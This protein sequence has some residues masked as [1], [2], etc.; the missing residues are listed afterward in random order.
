MTEASTTSRNLK[1]GLLWHTIGHGNLGIDALARGHIA[2]ISEAARQA[3]VSFEAV[4]MGSGTVAT[5]PAV[6]SGVRI[7]PP[8]RPKALLQGDFSFLETIRGCDVVFDIGE[9]DG[10][11]D[12]YGLRRYVL[13]MGSKLA[14]MGQGKPLYLAPQTI[15][16]FEKPLRRK[17][18][19]AL[20]RRASGVFTRD[21]LSTQFLRENALPADDHEF[22]DVAFALPFER[23]SHSPDRQ[24][25]CIN[26]SG[27]LYNKGY[28]GK[29]E[30]GMTLDYPAFTHQLI[31][32]LL[33]R[34][35]TE[36]HLI[37]HVHGPD[38]GPDNDAPVMRALAQRYPQIIM[39]PLYAT[40]TEAKGYM[41]GMDLVIA[42]RMHACIGAFSAGVP[43][44]PIAYSR[45]FNGLFGTL[46]Y[47]S[48]IDGRSM[49]ADAALESAI[50]MINN[51]AQLRAGV[52]KGGTVAKERIAQYTEKLRQI[53]AKTSSS[54]G[55][56]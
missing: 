6:P 45:K 30:L 11:T 46:G 13:Q 1:L 15:G 29:N 37:A 22:I 23:Q 5:P 34:P 40:S 50:V 17:A 52:V 26:V 41:S 38:D 55:S 16:P 24:R 19:V 42:G 31:E 9:G 48:Y 36:V 43:V 4:C 44:I 54:V 53:L 56:H 21:G 20:M 7:G 47:D 25:V 3:G 8:P 27:L 32:A 39:A 33:K 10:F 12:I 28:T 51:L 14:V 35:N 2:L 18:A 49:R